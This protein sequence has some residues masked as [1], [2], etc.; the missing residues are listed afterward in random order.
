VI[1]VT[2]GTG[3]IGSRLVEALCAVNSEVLIAMRSGVTI[4][5]GDRTSV[6]EFDGG[7][8]VRLAREFADRNVDC[9]VH[10]A[11]RFIAQHQPSDVGELIDAN[12]RYGAAVLEAAS[13][14]GASVVTVGSYWQ[15]AE[16]SWRHANSLYAASKTALDVVADYYEEYRGLQRRNVILY[17]VYGPGDPR[18]K[19]LAL[20]V[21]AA[22]S[23]S[24]LELSS[25]FQLINL[26]HVSD[27]VAGLI[28]AARQGAVGA[29]ATS[30]RSADFK[31]VRELV[32]A[33]E[34]A[35]GC[36]VDARWGKRPERSGEMR[37]PWDVAPILPGWKPS[38]AL[39]DGIREVAAASG[40]SAPDLR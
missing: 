10:L 32:T 21:D 19:I 37:E 11:T 30:L 35:L 31:S 20:I 7:D 40:W 18:Q 3:F 26:S 13:R 1:A 8:P 25:G 34:E 38:I 5:Q 15:H 4:R 14:A 17:D 6:V 28:L 9:V 23:G 36:P 24:P 16:S 2:G 12:V 33:V 22:L 27:I 29:K 39:N